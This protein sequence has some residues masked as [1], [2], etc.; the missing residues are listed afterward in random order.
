MV[1]V[2]TATTDKPFKKRSAKLVRQVAK[3]RLAQ[4]QDGDSLPLERF[5]LIGQWDCAKDGKQRIDPTSP[6]MRK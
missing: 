3:A 4:T 2:T 1:P 5:E 6:L